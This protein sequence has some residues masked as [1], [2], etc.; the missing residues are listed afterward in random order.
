MKKIEEPN[1]LDLEDVAYDLDGI[2]NI[3]NGLCR[4]ASDG[5]FSPTMHKSLY[6]LSNLIGEKSA[7]IEDVMKHELIR[8]RAAKED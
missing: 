1:I 3:L 8:L 2:A 6:M 4:L 7:I 5:D